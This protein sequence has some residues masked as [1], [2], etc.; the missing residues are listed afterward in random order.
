VLSVA[1]LL[2]HVGEGAAARRVEAA[3]AAW[4][5]ERAGGAREAVPTKVAGDEIAARLS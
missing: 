5:A 2:D 4:D 3:V 1:L